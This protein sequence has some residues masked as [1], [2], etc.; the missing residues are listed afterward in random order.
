MKLL[1]L[2]DLGLTDF[3]RDSWSRI[4]VNPTQ[5]RFIPFGS[6]VSHWAGSKTL[7]HRSSVTVLPVTLDFPRN[8]SSSGA[9]PDPGL[10]VPPLATMKALRQ[11]AICQRSWF[12]KPAEDVRNAGKTPVVGACSKTSIPQICLIQT[13]GKACN[14]WY[15]CVR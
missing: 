9:T 8:Y 14:S 5:C 7:R 6:S 15:S 3:P 11:R 1:V 13:S 4:Q 2:L 10:G 12:Q